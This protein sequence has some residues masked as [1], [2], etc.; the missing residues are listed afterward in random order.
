MALVVSAC[1]KEITRQK[2]SSPSVVGDKEALL[3]VLMD[4]EHW[5]PR[6]RRLKNYAFSKSTLMNGE[7]SVCREGHS[8]PREVC[9][10]IIRPLRVKNPARK[11]VGLLRAICGDVR[12]LM[13]VPSNVRVFC[14]V[15]DGMP[16]FRSHA[17]IGFSESAKGMIGDPNW[18]VAARANLIRVFQINGV[19]SLKNSFQ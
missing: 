9:Q 18:K 17:L 5:D 11:F 15:D 10:K 12:A 16:D 13:I 14:V 8:S 6:L 19:L 4:P 2:E 7:L 3:Y 1:P